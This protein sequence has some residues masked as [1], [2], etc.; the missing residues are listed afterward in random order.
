MKNQRHQNYPPCMPATWGR[1]LVMK[2]VFMKVGSPWA[3]VFCGLDG[4]WNMGE[5]APIIHDFGWIREGANVVNLRDF[6]QKIL[7]FW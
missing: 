6:L 4:W 3:A 5:S 7:M 2:A 1:F